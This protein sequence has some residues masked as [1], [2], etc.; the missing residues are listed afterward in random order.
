MA[1]PGLRDWDLFCYIPYLTK[2]NVLLPRHNTYIIHITKIMMIT[3]TK[4]LVHNSI[5]F[6]CLR[7]NK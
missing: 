5:I 6:L 1:S 4:I 3:F 7:I 2:V